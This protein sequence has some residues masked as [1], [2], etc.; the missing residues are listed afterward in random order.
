M[1]NCLHPVPPQDQVCVET[2]ISGDGNA[3]WLRI[4]VR[5]A[6]VGKSNGF[7]Q[8]RAAG[9]NKHG[10]TNLLVRC[11]FWALVAGVNKKEQAYGQAYP[12]RRSGEAFECCGAS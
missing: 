1:P 2:L 7:G 8:Q 12:P 10:V 11:S 6:L 5:G 3:A 9:D 4:V